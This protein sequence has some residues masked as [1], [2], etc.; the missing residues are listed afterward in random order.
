MATLSTLLLFVYV[1]RIRMR[2][3]YGN[4]NENRSFFHDGNEQFPSLLAAIVGLL[5]A[6][7]H[8]RTAMKCAV[9]FKTPLRAF[10]EREYCKRT[11]H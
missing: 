9:I 6:L 7:F 11:Q 4:A 5:S 8:A 10:P 1:I 2:L 3:L